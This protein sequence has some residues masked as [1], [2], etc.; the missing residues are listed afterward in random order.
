MEINP[1]GRVGS[2]KS[3]THIETTNKQSSSCYKITYG[4]VLVSTP[5][6]PGTEP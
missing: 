6:L 2:S 3:E 5:A 1:G 4:N